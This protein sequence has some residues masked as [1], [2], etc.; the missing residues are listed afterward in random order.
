MAVDQVGSL[1]I[2]L[3][4]LEDLIQLLHGRCG[5]SLHS[6]SIGQRHKIR[7]S[8]QRCLGVASS[9]EDALPL[10]YHAQH[11]VIEKHHRDGQLLAHHRAQLIQIHAEA[12]LRGEEQ[13]PLSSAGDAAADGRAQAVAHGA[14]TS[15]GQKLSRLLKVVELHRPHLVLAYIRSHHRIIGH[16]LSHRLDDI[17]R[18]E[19]A[20]PAGL[21]RRNL[22][23]LIDGLAPL[24]VILLLDILQKILQNLLHI[25]LHPQIRV[26][27]L[28]QL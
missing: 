11:A 6:E 21:R 27:V 28:A 4:G 10:P 25:A 14:E 13:S 18:N 17:L 24:C 12:S 19:L 2:V 1:V 22:L 5:V 15:G 23:I 3:D 16:G 9:V 20:F 7:L 26:N 8:L